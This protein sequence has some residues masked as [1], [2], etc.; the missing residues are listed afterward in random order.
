M[1]LLFTSAGWCPF[2]VA[3]LFPKNKIRLAILLCYLRDPRL[4]SRQWLDREQAP[5]C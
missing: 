4:K 5:D 3:N 1:K 2:V